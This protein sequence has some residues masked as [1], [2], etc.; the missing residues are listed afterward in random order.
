MKKTFG[1]IFLVAAVVLYAVFFPMSCTGCFFSQEKVTSCT[2]Y[3][4]NGMAMVYWETSMTLSSSTIYVD[5]SPAPATGVYPKQIEDGGTTCVLTGLSNG[6]TYTVTVENFDDSNNVYSSAADTVT[7]SASAEASYEYST[8]NPYYTVSNDTKFVRLTNV[9]GK[10]I[11]YANI[12][13]SDNTISSTDVRIVPYAAAVGSGSANIIT[14]RSALPSDSKARTAA[15]EDGVAELTKGKIK[16]FVPPQT[17]DPTKPI[18]QKLPPASR[19]VTASRQTYVD[20]FDVDT[21]TIGDYRYVYVD[22]DT[23]IS[24]FNKKKVTLRAIGKN[25]SNI[26]CLLWVDDDCWTTESSCSGTKINTTV[27][28][29]LATVFAKHYLHERDVFGEESDE[30]YTYGSSDDAVANTGAGLV[31]MTDETNSATK[32]YVNIVVYDIGSDYNLKTENQCGVVGYFYAKDYYTAEDMNED[33]TYYYGSNTNLFGN[34]TVDV[35]NYSNGGKYFYIDA[36]FCNY[37]GISNNAY[38]YNGNGGKA[39]DTVISTLVHEFQHMIDFN[40]K[41]ILHGQN[42]V[43]QWYNEMLSMMAEDMMQAQLGTTDAEAPRGARLPGFNE[44][45]Y[46]SGIGEYLSGSNAVISYS[47]AYAFGAWVARTYGGPELIQGISKNDKVG[48]DSVLDAIKEQTGYSL[49]TDQLM[50]QYIQACV[51]RT[52][53]AYNYKLPTFNVEAGHKLTYD[54]LDSKMT[55]IDLFSSNYKYTVKN[56][57]GNS[58]TYVGPILAS[59][60]STT[61]IRP[62]G[63]LLHAIGTVT[64]ADSVVIAFSPQI[65]SNDQVVIYVQDEFENEY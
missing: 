4:G 57:A 29:H 46:M 2:A 43:P 28:A 59:P 17:F 33:G 26:E 64:S 21:P 34:T 49:T 42:S 25:G 51:Y 16:N 24:T 7:P 54:N 39:S 3:P 11:V 48:M 37:S 18:E 13:S 5:I 40:Q 55:A 14:P 8:T 12:N 56:S 10:S 35:R 45:Y 27:A 63:F 47:T 9:N 1:K 31:S 15:E 23:S 61:D 32:T 30:I 60:S 65:N 62:T 6:T 38:T 36:A 41:N 50:K 20:D 22:A 53:F 52:D 19:S 58:T 44:Y